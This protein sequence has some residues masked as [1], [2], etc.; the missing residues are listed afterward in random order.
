LASSISWSKT[1]L[2]VYILSILYSKLLR[3][4]NII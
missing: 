3:K 2:S 1:A 4:G